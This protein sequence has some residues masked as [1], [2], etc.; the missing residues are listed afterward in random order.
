MWI[1]YLKVFQGTLNDNV[2]EEQSKDEKPLVHSHSKRGANRSEVAEINWIQVW[3]CENSTF[4]RR[5]A[6]TQIIRNPGSLIGFDPS[7]KIA[8]STLN[9][10]FGAS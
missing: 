7:T 4:G 8:T 9:G 10:G 5:A 3:S 6:V 2:Q 1:S